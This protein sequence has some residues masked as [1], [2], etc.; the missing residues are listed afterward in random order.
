MINSKYKVGDHV[1]FFCKY[2]NED[3]I[4]E[5]I[6]VRQA[7][8]NWDYNIRYQIHIDLSYVQWI[9]EKYIIEKIKR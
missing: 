6:N 1:K 9:E 4:G 2:K 3:I 5:I 7:N 8:L